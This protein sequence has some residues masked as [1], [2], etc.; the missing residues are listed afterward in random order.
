M[1]RE[2]LFFAEEM[3]TAR[4]HENEKPYFLPIKSLLNRC[5]FFIELWRSLALCSMPVPKNAK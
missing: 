3:P 2:I 4:F 1:A 5:K